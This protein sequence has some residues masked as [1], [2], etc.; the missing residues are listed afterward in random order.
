MSGAHVILPIALAGLAL[1]FSSCGPQESDRS[2]AKPSVEI[3]TTSPSLYLSIQGI[4][5]VSA[6]RRTLVAFGTREAEARTAIERV[7]GDLVERWSNPN[8]RIQPNSRLEYR[9]NVYLKFEAGRFVGWEQ[10]GPGHSMRVG[11][12]DNVPRNALGVLGPVETNR[13]EVSTGLMETFSAGG[14]RGVLDNGRVLSFEAGR[15]VCWDEH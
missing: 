14:I 3:R 2:D 9:G 7:T 4:E 6:G 15:S 8:C 5:L 10:A 11:I 13:V 12:A 1:L